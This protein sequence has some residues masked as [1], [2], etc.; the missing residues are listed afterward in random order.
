M[1]MK[2]VS[3]AV[4]GKSKAG[5]WCTSDA[6]VADTLF[7]SLEAMTASMAEMQRSLISLT[8]AVASTASRQ[9]LMGDVSSTQ[10]RSRHRHESASMTS[11]STT[12]VA[13]IQVIRNM[14]YWITGRRPDGKEKTVRDDAP[15]LLLGTPFEGTYIRA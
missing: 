3:I 10:K 7:C 11:P 5:L 13:P 15:T 12:S 14:N 6:R 1:K 8:N 4:E 2:L 9:T